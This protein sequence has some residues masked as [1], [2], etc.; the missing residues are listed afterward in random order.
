MRAYLN[1]YFKYLLEPLFHC[2]NACYGRATIGATGPFLMRK[3]RPMQKG[4]GMWCRA[5]RSVTALTGGLCPA[6]QKAFP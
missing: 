4:L 6:G 1:R 2:V 5:K 3:M